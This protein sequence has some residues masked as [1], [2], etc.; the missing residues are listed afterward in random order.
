MRVR[1]SPLPKFLEGALITAQREG[2][3]PGTENPR[4]GGSTPSPGTMV[5]KARSRRAQSL[6]L[7]PVYRQPQRRPSLPEPFRSRSRS[8]TVSSKMRHDGARRS[9]IHQRALAERMGLIHGNFCS[10]GYGDA[11]PQLRI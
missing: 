9:I 8:T 11:L 10:G 4:V 2:I 6:R 5:F 1:N 7:P 3:R